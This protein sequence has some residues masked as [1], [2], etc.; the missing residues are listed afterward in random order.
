MYHLENKVRWSVGRFPDSRVV[1]GIPDSCRRAVFQPTAMLLLGSIQVIFLVQILCLDRLHY[2][3]VASSIHICC[4]CG[5]HPVALVTTIPWI[6][7]AY[8]CGSAR[9]LVSTMVCL[10]CCFLGPHGI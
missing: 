2:V 10:F 4:C 6:M 9:D 1:G 8:L 7:A 5:F 3:E